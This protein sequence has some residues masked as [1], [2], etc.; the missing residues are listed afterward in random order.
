MLAMLDFNHKATLQDKLSE[1]LNK[2]IDQSL[3]QQNNSLE[4]R[5][6]LGASRLGVNCSRQLQYE[7]QHIPKD[8]D[9]G[10]SGQTLRNFAAGHLFEQLAIGWLRGAGFT[11]LTEDE[12][13]RQ[14]GFNAA[15]GLIAGH[16]DGIITAVAKGVNIQVPALW[17]MKS[18]HAKAWR[19]TALKGLV[20]AK[21]LYAAQIA[22]YQAYMEEGF[23]GI[24][25]NPALFTAINKDTAE[26]YHQLI[27]FDGEL[28]QR[29]SD[30]A[31]NIIRSCNAGELLPRIASS[32]DYHECKLCP[33]YN[34][35]WEG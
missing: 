29:M 11:L 22:L 27:P 7:F 20:I 15:G 35:C 32:S 25:A 31:V 19:E 21:P 1:Q 3:V 33:Y 13:G 4:G 17:E 6:Y 10:F 30:K 9:K 12:Y 5:S 14:F 28:A 26:L 18:M 2:L 24:S 8:E 23:A 34:R 16:V